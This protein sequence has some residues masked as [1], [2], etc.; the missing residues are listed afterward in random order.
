M[1]SYT[2]AQLRDPG[3][4]S[5]IPTAKLPAKY[6]RM[7]KRNAAAAQQ[8]KAVATNPLLNPTTPLAGK[9]LQTAATQLTNAELKPKL[10]A[11]DQQLA[12]TTQ[13]GTALVGKAG[14]VYQQVAANEAQNVARQNAL[15]GLLGAGLANVGASSRASLDQQ[16]AAEAQRQ[17]AD[18]SLRGGGLSGGSSDQVAQAITGLR[19][20]SDAIQRSAEN[21]AALQTSNWGN[22]TNAMGESRG[23][24]AGEVQSELLNRLAG[25]QVKINQS[26]ADLQST[27][28]DTQAKNLQ[29]LRQQGFEN[30]ATMQGLGIKQ[31]DIAA[32]LQ[33]ARGDQTVAKQKIKAAAQTNAANRKSREHIAAAGRSIAK[34]NAAEKQRH[35]VAMENKPGKP[36]KE[37]VAVAE[38]RRVINN[39]SSEISDLMRKGNTR[40]QAAA[41]IRK[42]AQQAKQTMPADI[43]SSALDLA[44]DGHISR[45]NLAL[46]KQQGMVIPKQWLPTAPKRGRLASFPA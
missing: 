44:Y 19:G 35:D 31:S 20:R 37:P 9:S 34:M 32:S 8:A 26:K 39:V 30:L 45:R 12:T 27:R 2:R 38:R 21:T 24:H 17:Q 10:S 42:N 3:Q 15:G 16:A 40:S 29:T 4:R 14:N 36:V 6:Q 22:L 46:L 43:L 7:R 13:Q 23:L 5:K 11:L 1:A 25:Q 41:Q 18:A 28:G 33:K